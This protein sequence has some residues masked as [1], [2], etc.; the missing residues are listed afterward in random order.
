MIFDIINKVSGVI[1]V[2][3][4]VYLG[5]W[6]NNYEASNNA[7]LFLIATALIFKE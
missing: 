4:A 7:Y 5:F 3:C 2:V 6:Q 1:V